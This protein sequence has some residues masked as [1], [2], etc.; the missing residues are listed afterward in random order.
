MLSLLKKLSYNAGVRRIV[1]AIGLS[2]VARKVYWFLAKPYRN[3]F[4]VKESGATGQF[5][6]H[7]PGELRLLEQAILGEKYSLG[8]LLSIINPG[9]VIWDVGA[10]IGLYT[11]LIARKV[12]ERGQVIAF[13]PECQSFKRLLENLKLNNLTNVWVFQKALGEYEE[14]KIMYTGENG[15]YCSL[16]LPT[17]RKRKDIGRQ[18][19]EVVSGDEFCKKKGLPFPRIVNIDVEGYEYSVLQGLRWT[20]S[21]P[22][23][24]AILLEAHPLMLPTDIKVDSLVELLRTTGFIFSD[25]YPRGREYHIFALKD[26]YIFI[27]LIKN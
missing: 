6:I 14:K 22:N 1:N 18:T 12:G 24:E 20:I 10:S 4:S 17:E 25:I 19:V 11:V 27:N 3:I 15:Y 21:H 2:E 13:E 23:C 16:T 7:T 5:F 8:R 26:K 9:D